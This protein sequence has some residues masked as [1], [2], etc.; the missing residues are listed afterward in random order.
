MTLP[1]SVIMTV[2][3]GDPYLGEAVSSLLGQTYRDFEL[4]VVNNGSTDNTAHTLRSFDD[5]RIR[6]ITL[7]KTIGRTEVLNVALSQAQGEY[8]AVQDA[9]DVSM[10]DRLEKQMTFMADNTELVLSGTWCERISGT[11]ER[12]S[13]FRP[14][15]SHE[16]IVNGCA[17]ENPFAHSS[18]MYKREIANSLGGYPSQFAYN[19][20]FALCLNLIRGHRAAILP[21]VLVKI[22]VH[23]AQATR[24]PEMASRR[25]KEVF[26]LL[27]YA[28]LHPDVSPEL[29]RSGKAKATLMRAQLLSDEGLQAEA[30]SW[31][32]RFCMLYPDVWASDPRQW[33]HIAMTFA[34]RR[35]RKL[36]SR[37]KTRLRPKTAGF[38]SHP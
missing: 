36:A 27:V 13:F 22:R 23:P 15:P 5:P 25:I 9:D 26:E 37:A 38:A 8:V 4:V 16:E 17:I 29:R 12:L 24:A 34:G 14:P 10:P 30:L 28:G 6:L 35:A 32:G 1:L 19:Q 11:G 7:E 2:L 20:D 3:N 21:S 18:L 31:L 33:K